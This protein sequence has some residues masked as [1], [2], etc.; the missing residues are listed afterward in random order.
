MN[1]YLVICFITFT[2]ISMAQFDVSAGMGLNFFSSPD[3]RDYINSNF[4][5]ADE[6]SSFNTS[7][8]F[9]GEVGY[10]LNDKYQIAVEYTLNLYSFNSTFATSR[11]DIQ[12]GQH[13]PSLIGYYMSVG[14]GYKFKFG[15]GI[16]L[17]SAS[18]D[19][20]LY[21]TVTNYTTSGVGILLKAQGDTRLGG[22]F[23]ALI[24]GKMSYDMPGE[25]TTLTNGNFDLSSFGVALKLGIAYY[26]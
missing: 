20:E 4:A 7:A 5:S 13:K 12:I 8:D 9:F 15:A 1:K 10:N 18:V 23:Y 16:G 21:G 25:I 17:R 19:E 26:L 11:Y 6:M 14:K 24:A 3:L 2:S 22:N